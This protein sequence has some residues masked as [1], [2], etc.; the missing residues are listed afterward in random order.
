MIQPRPIWP[1]NRNDAHAEQQ[2]SEKRLLVA[3]L[4]RAVDDI[5]YP[6][7]P[8][9]RADAKRW[10]ASDDQSSA[11]TFVSACAVLGLDPDAVRAEVLG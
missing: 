5:R 4:A 11:F 9:A 2:S 7:A 3:V 6:A 1:I 8:S 10:I